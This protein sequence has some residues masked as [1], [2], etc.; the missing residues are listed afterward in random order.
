MRVLFLWEYFSLIKFG[1]VLGG[2]SPPPPPIICD[3]YYYW[4]ARWSC[5][6]AYAPPIPPGGPVMLTATRSARCGD[7]ITSKSF[8]SL[9]PRK[10]L[11]PPILFCPGPKARYDGHESGSFHGWE[12]G[13]LILTGQSKALPYVRPAWRPQAGRKGGWL[14][15]KPPP[16]TI[17]CACMRI[18]WWAGTTT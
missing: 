16:V 14:A 13:N 18:K 1:P 6:F 7:I 5:G 4:W 2:A 8:A 15:G 9:S 3:N 12:W 11:G 10:E 17:L